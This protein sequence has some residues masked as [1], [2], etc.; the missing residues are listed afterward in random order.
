MQLAVG[1]GATVI[2]SSIEAR[3]GRLKVVGATPVLYGDGVAERVRAAAGGQLDA[4]FDVVG[5]TP[6][7]QL[8]SLVPDPSPVVTI[9]NYTATQAGARVTGG[10]ADSRPMPALDGPATCLART[11]W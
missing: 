11:R 7:K 4:V 1:R 2:A 5:K 10:D 9:A 3:F 6:S 8:I